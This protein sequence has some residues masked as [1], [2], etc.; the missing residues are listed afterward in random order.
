MENTVI[1]DD[2][3]SAR[4]VDERLQASHEGFTIVC[5]EC[6][7]WDVGVETEAAPGYSG[8]G[9]ILLVCDSCGNSTPISYM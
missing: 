4:G 7:S 8:M 1:I 2:L 9:A 3:L 6:A 5:Q